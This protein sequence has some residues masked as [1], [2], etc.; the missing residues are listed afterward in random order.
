MRYLTLLLLIAFPVTAYAQAVFNKGYIINNN[1][2]SVYGLIEIKANKTNA[3]NCFYKN[4]QNSEVQIFSPGEI[5]G[6]RFEGNKYYV[7]RTVSLNDKEEQLFLEYLIDGIVDVYYYDDGDLDHFF[8]DDGGGKLVELKKS[9]KRAENY[10]GWGYIESTQHIGILKY[11]FRESAEISKQA[12][13][14]EL[15]RKALVDIAHDY[16][17]EVCKDEA[18]I[19]YEKEKPHLENLHFGLVVGLNA[20]TAAP[21]KLKFETYYLKNSDFGTTWSPSVGFFVNYNFLAVNAHMFFYYQGTLSKMSLKSSHIYENAGVWLTEL[22]YERTCFNSIALFKY[23]LSSENKVR[24]NL[25]V[26][27][28]INLALQHEYRRNTLPHSYLWNEGEQPFS[29]ADCG[30][31]AGVGFIADLN[32]KNALII[33]LTY[34]RGLTLANNLRGNYFSLNIG[35]QL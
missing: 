20:I 24:P 8:I 6:F 17:N 4:D 23:E 30:P 7:T 35:L 11:I 12:E 2:D 3:K 27:G 16:H 1:N 18:C 29:G 5:K 31:A 9:Q 25:H 28:F 34:Q 32:G 22:S 15:N 14:V 13:T 19:I 10:L 33:D 26:G 21:Y